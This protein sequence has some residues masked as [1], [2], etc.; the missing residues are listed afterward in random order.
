MKNK[1]V[2][3]NTRRKVAKNQEICHCG[4]EATHKVTFKYI[5]QGIVVKA[6]TQTASV[7]SDSGEDTQ[8]VCDECYPHTEILVSMT[9]PELN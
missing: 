1:I 5:Y 7:I 6:N 2:G 9:V 4:K 3:L 8:F